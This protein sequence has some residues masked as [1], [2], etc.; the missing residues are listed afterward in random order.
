V[1]VVPVRPKTG[2]GARGPREYAGGCRGCPWRPLAAAPVLPKSLYQLTPSL[3]RF[4]D[5]NLS[6]KNSLC[7]MHE[8][9]IFREHG[10]VHGDDGDG[11]PSEMEP[12]MLFG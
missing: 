5:K 9:R 2:T 8:L 4:P 12:R 3:S 11:E 7:T 10:G 1:H 6:L